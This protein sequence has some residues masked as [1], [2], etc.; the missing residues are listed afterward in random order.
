MQ[1]GAHGHAAHARAAAFFP[2]A[3]AGAGAQRALRG[4]LGAGAMGSRSG[5][6][7]MNWRSDTTSAAVS[8]L[9]P[10]A[11]PRAAVAASATCSGVPRRITSDRAAFTASRV[12]RW[13]SELAA[14]SSGP[15]CRSSRRCVGRTCSDP[16]N[17]PPSVL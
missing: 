1:A 15:A 12:R 8:M 6:S 16:V 17:E 14:A 3:L 7:R 13:R 11:R 4:N 9:R 10:A 5:A 2:A